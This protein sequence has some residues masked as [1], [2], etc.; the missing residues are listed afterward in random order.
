MKKIIVEGKKICQN[1]GKEFKSEKTLEKHIK[2]KKCKESNI[3]KYQEQI[4]NRNKKDLNDNKENIVTN[5]SPIENSDKKI[6][7]DRDKRDKIVRIKNPN[8]IDPNDDQ[9]NIMMNHFD[10]IENSDEKNPVNGDKIVRNTKSNKKTK[11]SLG[12]S[13]RNSVW[14]KYTG[15]TLMNSKCLCCGIANI[16]STNFHCGHIIS[17]NQGGDATIHNLRPIC[18]LCNTSM[19]IENMED[20]MSRNGYA[21][22]YNWNGYK[23]IKEP[24]IKKMIKPKRNIV[25]E[26]INKFFDNIKGKNNGADI[27]NLMNAIQIEIWEKHLEVE[28]ELHDKKE[29]QRANNIANLKNIIP[30]SHYGNI[31]NMLNRSEYKKN[32]DDWFI[33]I[34]QEFVNFLSNDDAL[35]IINE[36]FSD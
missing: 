13:L 10:P 25:I 16:S 20:F 1:C 24:E 36:V 17:E 28:K 2:E 35:I 19:G 27:I 7:E 30:N 11:K 29:Y 6:P 3:K 4:K 5:T 9:E 14:V 31:I 26:K 23:E 15:G 8:K 34:K 22:P 32:F 12:A 18:S 33:K 21:K